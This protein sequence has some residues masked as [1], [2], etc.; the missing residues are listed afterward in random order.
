MTESIIS[1][2]D[3]T[4]RFFTD[5]GQV[6]AVSGVSFDLYGGEV[7]AVVGESGSGKSVTGRSL[8]D[9]IEPPGAIVDGELW[10]HSPELAA[11]LTDHPDAVD[12]DFVDVRA[13]SPAVRRSLCG[14]EFGMI[15]QD[16]G[17]A[18]NPSLTVG[19]QIAEAVECNA[20]LARGETYGLSNL[21]RD[22]LSPASSFVSP[23][24]FER[25]VD[26]LERVDIPDPAARADEYPHQ[27]S[28]GM[29]QRAMIAQALAADPT[30]LIADEPTTGLDVT[31]QA[32]IIE[33]LDELRIDTGA[34]ILLITHNLGV[35]ADI[36]DRTAVMYAGEFVEVGPTDRVFDHPANPYTE[37]LLGSL[38][39]FDD[40]NAPIT[41][42]PGNVPNLLAHEM[43]PGCSFAPRCPAATDECTATDPE[44][45]PVA[46]DS[47]HRVACIHADIAAD[48]GSS[49]LADSTLRPIDTPAPERGDVAYE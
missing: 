46:T 11:D 12:G 49:S 33:L 3:L 43:P 7:L 40:P 17:A 32:G 48:A 14:T 9:L 20:R 21:L 30:V 23:E 29:L 2:R 16:P 19:E 25:A 36:A 22:V 41:P 6:N 13:V 31:I 47:S 5:A 42:I 18:F 45:E 37:G 26:L 15:F 38:P 27:F 1:V 34:S 39:T 4:T 10:F 35:V 24:S 44:L 8:M 28:G